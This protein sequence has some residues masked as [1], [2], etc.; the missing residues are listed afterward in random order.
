[1]V[2]SVRAEA[3]SGSVGHADGAVERKDGDP[4]VGSHLRGLLRELASLLRQRG[5]EHVRAC[6]SVQQRVRACGLETAR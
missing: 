5:R 6:N 3:R 4:Q 1:M 2:V